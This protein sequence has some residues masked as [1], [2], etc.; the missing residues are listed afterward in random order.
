MQYEVTAISQRVYK[1][2]LDSN[3]SDSVFI[4]YTQFTLSAVFVEEKNKRKSSLSPL[5]KTDPTKI[6]FQIFWK[7][8]WFFTFICNYMYMYIE[9]SMDLDEMG[10]LSFTFFFKPRQLHKC[11]H[12]CFITLFMVTQIDDAVVAFLSLTFFMTD[13][14]LRSY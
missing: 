6:F 13:I 8:E 11:G 2:G 12:I 3:L 4:N 14:T 9:S 5:C 10:D 1:H 7:Q